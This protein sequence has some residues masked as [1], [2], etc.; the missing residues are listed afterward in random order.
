[1]TENERIEK[2][3][4]IRRKVLGA[5]YV[6]KPGPAPTKLQAAFQT[7]TVENCWGSVWVRE[8]LSHKQR[9]ML[10]LAMLSVK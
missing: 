3:R 1:M 9:S 2:G 7:F 8:G 5:S 10:N 6:D 4:T